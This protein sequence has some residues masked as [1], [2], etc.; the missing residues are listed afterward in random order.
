MEEST[1]DFQA[2]KDGILVSGTAVLAAGT[3]GLA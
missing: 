2:K 1:K 3:H